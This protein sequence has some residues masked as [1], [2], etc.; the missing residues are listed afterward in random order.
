[1][2]GIGLSSIEMVARASRSSGTLTMNANITAA[3]GQAAT[4]HV[5]DKYPIVTAQYSGAPTTA[6]G[7]QTQVPPPVFNF[8]DLGVILKVTPTIH[9]Q[10]EVS[11]DLNAEYKVLG[12][13]NLNGI[14]TISNRK[15]DAKVRLLSSQCAIVSGLVTEND[16]DTRSGYPW[17]SRI[18]LLGWLFRQTT[19]QHDFTQTLLVLTPHIV[20]PPPSTYL[21]RE[22][23]LGPETKPLTPL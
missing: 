6:T 1:M 12:A 14:P 11:L 17:L 9:D 10:N 18:P 21:T 13:T 8:E 19:K 22:I 4:F 20:T 23:W 2:F 16:T 5:G 15:F 3:D 7:G